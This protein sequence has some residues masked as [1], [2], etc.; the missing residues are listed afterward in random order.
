VGLFAGASQARP[1]RSLTAPGKSG[2]VRTSLAPV[3]YSAPGAC[4]AQLAAC[5]AVLFGQAPVPPLVRFWQ[6][7]EPGNF[8]RPAPPAAPRRAV[9]PTGTG[10]G[11][12]P[13]RAPRRRMLN[14]CA[15][16]RPTLLYCAH[17]FPGRWTALRPHWLLYRP[18]RKRP[19]SPG[20]GGCA[21]H[22]GE[23]GPC[24][25]V[26]LPLRP[27]ASGS[28]GLR[29]APLSVH[30]RP[31]A[32]RSLPCNPPAGKGETLDRRTNQKRGGQCEQ[33]NKKKK[34]NENRGERATNK[35][36]GGQARRGGPTQP[37]CSLVNT[38][39]I[40]CSNRPG[41]HT[42]GVTTAFCSRD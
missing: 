30:E 21:A 41:Q 34:R 9:P 6:I 1:E 31:C 26:C 28:V 29:A 12:P 35:G 23:G 18:D 24:L 13:D 16:H 38:A 32:F 7:Q 39:A 37:Y 19:L 22:S 17:A 10:T 14:C 5:S 40:P 15:G 25:V 2:A 42:A 3:D 8:G 36:G 33:N 27:P 20:Q 4:A 11:P